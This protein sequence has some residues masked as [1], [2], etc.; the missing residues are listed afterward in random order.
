MILTQ[1]AGSLAAL[2]CGIAMVVL[3][4]YAVHTLWMVLLFLRRQ[5]TRRA[6]EASRPPMPAE[7][8]LP[9][10]LVQ[11]PIF[12]EAAVAV[13]VIA[14]AGALDWP[15]DRLRIQ[16]LDDS[17]DGTLDLSR[18]AVRQLTE[19]G[20]QAELVHRTD[21][22]GF[23]AGALQAGLAQDDAPFVALFDA[24]FVPPPDWLRRTVPVLLADPD[25]AFL[26]TRWTHLNGQASVLTRAQTI[27]IDAHF[28][29]EQNARTLNGLPLS[30][31]GACGIWRRAAIEAGGG[32]QADTLA[33]DLD[34]S[35]RALLAGWR[36][37]FRSDIAVP[38]EVPPSVEAWRQQQFRWSKG[39]MEVCLKLA[40]PV[41][42]SSLTG[43]Q[44]LA[45]LIHLS[46]SLAHPAALVIVL[47]AP[48][49]MHL[50]HERPA[51][52]DGIAVAA[53]AFS[54]AAALT[55]A[56]V[57]RRQLYGG[58]LWRLLLEVPMLLSMSTGLAIVNSRA[59]VM[60]LL[61]RRTA[62]V[63]TPKQGDRPGTG[64]RV[65]A[66]SSG[67]LELA[68]AGWAVSAAATHLTIVTPMLLVF[69]GGFFWIG[70]HSLLGWWASRGVADSSTADAAYAGDRSA[71]NGVLPRRG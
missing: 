5:E 51:W 17:T 8:D 22:T 50:L 32:W 1:G 66:A 71:A 53:L 23:K 24:D 21:R 25:L 55:T 67:L 28:F 56:M 30:F 13:R 9:V 34:L 2:L 33:E 39:N 16:V 46:H 36:G 15:R 62:F 68:V 4:L 10:V 49:V 48:L 43:K 29:I 20:I 35:Y 45:G 19:A 37:G 26:Q 27:A 6:R 12:N 61:R 59:V 47:T 64:P 69:I 60:A 52:L 44:K 40:G 63:R 38:G 70:V 41:L 42:R 54:M 65:S 18:N 14:A 31:N 58:T 57:S 3:G 11:L 7:S